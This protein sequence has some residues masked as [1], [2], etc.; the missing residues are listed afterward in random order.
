MRESKGPRLLARSRTLFILFA[1]AAY[2]VRPINTQWF[3]QACV[4]VMAPWAI[5]TVA[6]ELQYRQI[7]F[8]AYHALLFAMSGIFMLT[9]LYNRG[10]L[11]SGLMVFAFAC[12][13]AA[14][15]WRV[16][17]STG[18]AARDRKRRGVC[19]IVVL[20]CFAAFLPFF[21]SYYN[22]SGWKLPWLVEA[23]PK[24]GP[25]AL[26]AQRALQAFAYSRDWLLSDLSVMTFVCAAM[27]VAG[28]A[29]RAA[30]EDYLRRESLAVCALI[31]VLSIMLLTPAVYSVFLGKPVTVPGISKSFGI[32]SPGFFDARIRVA[33]M[34]PN[35]TSHYG[36]IGLFSA[37]YCIYGVKRRWL[38]A[39]LAAASLLFLMAI[40]HTQSRTSNIALG[41]GVGALVF[42]WVY[43]S[44]TSRRWRIPAGLLA[45][46]VSIALTI[47][48]I[49]TL[50]AVDIYVSLRRNV[51]LESEV[52]AQPNAPQAASESEPAPTP[53]SDK[54]VV[55]GEQKWYMTSRAGGSGLI[56]VTGNGRGLVWKEGIDYLIH[57]PKDMIFGMGAGDIVE[58]LRAYNPD[59]ASSKRW[60]GR[61][62]HAAL[63]LIAALFCWSWPGAAARSS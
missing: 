52:V 44:L 13:V 41:A 2:W 55:S 54:I 21:I 34:H 23:A 5:A 50:F 15:L 36:L 25:E 28:I 7:A 40:A 46:A 35:L 4:F 26:R 19:L 8:S 58:R 16:C 18:D 62:V 11:L 51:T 12:G 33:D 14:L 43:L 63:H 30:D 48:S 1:I 31:V 47:V 22:G 9:S 57:H 53:P 59:P 42:R 27:L 3:M 37:L 49:N 56:N 39:L 24:R 10:V 45:G 32:T 6:G 38:K 29:P 17:R 20:L 60:P 61:R